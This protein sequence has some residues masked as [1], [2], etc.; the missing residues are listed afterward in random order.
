LEAFSGVEIPMPENNAPQG[1]SSARS[2]QRKREVKLSSPN[3]TIN[4][5][6]QI[7][8]EADES[9]QDNEERKKLKATPMSALRKI[10]FKE[11][12][13]QCYNASAADEAHVT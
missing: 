2:T 11:S 3:A 8:Q 12:E 4:K 6:H 10:F 1:P 9:D 5:H 13:C 7:E